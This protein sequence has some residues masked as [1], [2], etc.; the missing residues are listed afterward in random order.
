MPISDDNPDYR[1][2]VRRMVL[3]D[4]GFVQLTLKGRIRARAAEHIDPAYADLRQITVRPVAIRGRRQLQFSYLDAKQDITRNY[5][6]DE[7]AAALD[8]ALAVPFANVHVRTA[9]RDLRVQL[10]KKGK[11]ILHEDASAPA[12]AP[13]LSHD[14][15]KALPIPDTAPDAYLQAVGI[16]NSRGEVRPSMRDKFR[17]VNEFLK[18]F[19]HTGVL[20]DY[21]TRETP[22]RIV[23][24]GCGSAYLTLA[25][26][27]YLNDL[28]G[29]PAALDG[30]DTNADLIAKNAQAAADLGYSGACFYAQPIRDYVPDVPPD[31]VLALHACDTATDDALYQGIRHGA[32]LILAA[33]CCHHHLHAQMTASP[34]PM[35]PVLRH[36]ILKK[37]MGD[38]LTD[39]FRALLL[40]MHGYKTDVV[41]F[42]SGEHTDRNLMIRAV[43][44]A[45]IPTADFEREYASL[46]AF[47]NVT[48]YLETLLNG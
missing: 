34:D 47:W 16:M 26:Y 37:R 19:A 44:R 40:R 39:S 17:Q 43:R 36:G 24:F 3:E 31:V 6:G 14:R 4:A 20:D 45:G 48:P 9:A 21:A 15:E 27:H 10:T 28:R 1:A 35:Q 42:I 25:A 30:V 8:A 22:V 23:D 46:K 13:D 7:A 12:A 11:A 33:P 29:I 38:L 2:T 32:G 5:A 18:L 41:E